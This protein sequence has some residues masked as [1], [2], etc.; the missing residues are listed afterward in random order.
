LLETAHLALVERGAIFLGLICYHVCMS[1]TLTI[2]ATSDVHVNKTGIIKA[3]FDQVHGTADLLLIGGDLHDGTVAQTELFMNLITD[4]KIP[5]VLIFG[6]HD[7]NENKLTEMKDL[8]F[9]HEKMQILEGQYVE[10]EIRGTR[11]GI[12][13]TKGFGGGFAPNELRGNIGD[14]MM[15]DFRKEGDREV[16]LLQQALDEMTERKPDIKIAMSHYAPFKEVVEGE[17]PEIYASLGNSKLGDV[18]TAAQVHLA[19]SG[20]AH[21]CTNGLKV[22][23][24]GIKTANIG[25]KVNHNKMCFFD[26]CDDGS[27]TMR[28]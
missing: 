16:S 20:H 4:V 28:I 19:V 13:G 7:H 22:T 2:A 23:P 6:N 17:N 3:F 27:I 5:I 11:V 1:K 8:L 15:K 18:I 9:K 26:F 21:L 14:Q 12:A 10:Y 24:Q 25:Y